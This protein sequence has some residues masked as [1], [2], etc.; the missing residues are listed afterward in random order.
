VSVGNRL[1]LA[2]AGLHPD[3]VRDLVASF[4][5]D[6][7][8]L[9]AIDSGKIEVSC[10]AIA[11]LHR[12]VSEMRET[13]TALGIRPVWRGGAGY[14]EPL[15]W[16]PDAPDVLFVRGTL[17]E[18]PAVAVVGTRRCTSYGRS[19]ARAYGVAIADAGWVTVSGLARGIDAE[20][21][22]GTLDGGGVGVAVLGSGSNVIY[23]SEHRD[24]HDCL[25]DGGGAV[26]TEYPPGTPPEAWRFPPRN[27]IIAGMSACVVVVEAAIKGGALITAMYAIDQA[28]AVLAVP[29]DIDRAASE[30]CN[31]LIR[32]GA[33]PVL[34][35]D[36]LTEALSLIVGPP[37][38]RGR[39]HPDGDPAVLAV[40]GSTGTSLESVVEAT[41][42]P[43]AEVLS[44]MARLEASGAVTRVGGLF[45]LVRSGG[46]RS[47]GR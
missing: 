29:G 2:M 37:E 4:G 14:P 8:V 33:V 40:L 36:D 12:P 27:R 10:R 18:R 13:L 5:S 43:T 9:R 41:G 46:E 44:E 35:P 19:L 25:V 6:A 11:A 30:G 42:L 28:K 23:P 32:D 3:R 24:L 45:T 31:L 17:S 20:A 7:R 26:V 39:S 15:S 1:R 21:H 16:L 47:R 22:R 34:G 38:T